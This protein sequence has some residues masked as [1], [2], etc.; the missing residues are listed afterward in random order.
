V[1]NFALEIWDD[2]GAACT[3][4]SVRW[5]E[6]EESET[7]RFFNRFTEDPENEYYQAAL[8]LF[9]LISVPIKNKYGATND[10]I[11]RHEKRAQALPPRPNNKIEEIAILGVN[12]PLRVFCYRI[13]TEILVL[14]NGGIKSAL[15][16]Q[17]SPDLKPK[18]NEAQE[19]AKRIEAA[20]R[21]GLIEIDNQKRSLTDGANTTDIY[22]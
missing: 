2:E 20:L 8:E 22:L 17:D 9:E 14:F 7:D 3:L 1:N 4:Y 16:A 21:A 18:F 19:F 11:N 5:E 12:F 10:F 6:L 15:T 13:N